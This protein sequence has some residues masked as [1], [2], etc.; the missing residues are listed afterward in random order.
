MTNLREDSVSGLAHPGPP[1]RSHAGDG[2]MGADVSND[3]RYDHAEAC[4]DDD[5]PE[6]R[7]LCPGDLD[8]EPH[9]DEGGSGHEPSDRSTATEGSSLRYWLTWG[10]PIAALALFGAS[11]LLPHLHLSSWPQARTEHT[12]A[13]A[14][15]VRPLNERQSTDVP[16][17]EQ[18]STTV[19]VPPADAGA[20]GDP[21]DVGQDAL[22]VGPVAVQV[23]TA[24]TSPAPSSSPSPPTDVLAGP[25]ADS[26]L[27]RLLTQS[28]PE[29]LGVRDPEAA[30]SVAA[31][32]T[33]QVAWRALSE[34]LTAGGWNEA[35][36]QAH[37]L[38]SDGAGDRPGRL[39]PETTVIIMWSASSP[40]GDLQDRQMSAVRM[41][42]T[43]PT[44]T[45]R[46]ITTL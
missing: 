8:D 14:A 17:E 2:E 37:E 4:A 16:L 41:D 34:D 3:R 42:T 39:P 5:N 7:A 1:E 28:M 27:Q 10:L 11:V 9:D 29:R 23:P 38:L 31:E 6:S 25:V 35:H 45:T 36:M 20:E 15:P 40:S 12:T 33:V 22:P 46:E 24:Q 13:G 30:T 21:H 18:T 26:D 19:P 44:S 32:V 43:G